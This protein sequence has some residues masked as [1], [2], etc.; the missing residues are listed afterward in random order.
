MI[1]WHLE[2]LPIKSLKDHAK[3]PRQI[4]KEQFQHLEALIAKFGLIDK[5]IVNK[6]WTIIGGHQRVKILKKMKAKTVECWLPN[7]QLEQGDIDRLCIG[8]NLNQGAWD[9]DILANQWDAVE[10][11]EWGFTEE[12]L[13]GKTEHIES[14]LDGEDDEQTAGRAEEAVTQTGDLYELGDHRLLCGDSTLPD[15]VTNLLAGAEPTLMVTDPPYGVNYD[16]GW[17]NRQ[18]CKGKRSTGKVQNDDQADWSIAWSLFP[19]SVAYIWCASLFLSEVAKTLDSC[20]FERKSLLIW[21]KQ[22]FALSRGDYH[23]QHETCWYAVK[24]GQSHNWQGSRKECTIWEICNHSAFGNKKDE[25]KT[26]HS[27]QKPIECMARPIRNNSAEGEG[28]YDPFVGSGT[29]IIACEKLNRKCY[30]M[31]IDPVY[32]DMTVRRWMK[33]TGKTAKRNGEEIDAL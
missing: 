31:E 30:A 16:A 20:D 3:N 7:E 17:R 8:L 32:C 9:F 25:E 11:L 33:A 4:S 5:P 10:L 29:T 22:H 26:N 13:L 12:Q 1:N 2:V 28:V 21:K 27:T 18:L 23:W 24:K 14:E 6:D 15:D 19:G